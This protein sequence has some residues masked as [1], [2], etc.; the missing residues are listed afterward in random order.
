MVMSINT[1][2]MLCTYVL[3]LHTYIVEE[4]SYLR[5]V[6]HVPFQMWLFIDK[7]S[8]LH[9]LFA[10]VCLSLSIQA[11]VS[12]WTQDQRLENGFDPSLLGLQNQT[13]F[14]KN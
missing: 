4:Y 11:L 10:S 9:N 8:I 5:L 3:L 1:M 6:I 2:D 13:E 14:A 7:S 12:Q